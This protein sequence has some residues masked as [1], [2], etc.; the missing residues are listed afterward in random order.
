MRRV[1]DHLLLL[2][3]AMWT[4]S[5]ITMFFLLLQMDSIVHN[6]LYDYGLQFSYNWANPYWGLLRLLFLWMTVPLAVT[7]SIIAYSYWTGRGL[8]SEKTRIPKKADSMMMITCGS[9]GKV[10]ARPL[11]MLDFSSGR[12]RMVN[13]CPYCNKKLE[14]PTNGTPIKEQVRAD[15][16]LQKNTTR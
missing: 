6:T 14:S 13:V 1:P 15:E 8:P 3:I 9:C 4:A 16:T 11:C 12:A 2:F 10:F 5:Y 7:V